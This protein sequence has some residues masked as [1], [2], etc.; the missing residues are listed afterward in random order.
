MF[1]RNSMVTAHKNTDISNADYRVTL[2]GNPNVGKSTIFNALTGLKQ[3][4]GN[5]TGKTVE[6]FSGE[7]KINDKSFEITDLP[8]TYSMISFS[9]EESVAKEFLANTKSDCVVIVIDSNIIERNLSFAL[10]VLSLQRN[11]VLCLNLCDEAEKNGICIDTDELSLN[12]GIPVVCTCATKKKGLNELKHIIYDVCCGNIKCFK[13]E[14][15]FRDIDV[16]NNENYKKTSEQLSKLSE[17]ICIRCVNYNC[18][19]PINERAKKL[20]KILT[21]KATGIPIMLLLFG[22]LFWITAVGANYPSEWLSMLFDSVKSELYILFD[23]LSVPIFIKGLLIDGVYTTLTWVIAV[24]LPPMAIFFP[25]FSLIEDSGYLPRIAFNLDK[26]FSKC[27]AHGKQSLTMAMGIGCNACGVTGCRI[28]ESPQERLVAILT[29]NFMPCNGRFPTLI[30]IIMMFFAGSTFGF[31][32]SLKV[33]GILLI[34][35]VLCVLVT[36][37]ISKLLSVTVAKGE[38]SGFA[39][40]LPP[41]RKPQIF[42]TIVRSLLDRTLFVLGRAIVVSAPA[43]AIIW[44][45][46]NI[47][48]NDISILSYCT[49]FLDPFGK[50]LGLDGVIIMAFVL[51]FPANETV[52]PIIIMSYMASGTLTDFTSYEQLYE[53]FS[54]NG[55]TAVTAVCMMIMCIMHFPCSTTCLTIKKET[56]NLKWT[57][58]SMVFPTLI[59]IIFCMITANIMRIF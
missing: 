18:N 2:T 43:G 1:A 55:W 32:S 51:G 54:A 6:C 9:E 49:Q 17:E 19:A 20:D 33:A 14:R 12:L 37:A 48:I 26:F 31:A 53:I 36:L 10:Q 44:L 56:G 59:G 23:L 38:P 30:A 52:V 47:Y 4:T 29:N 39:L 21:S 8:G 35:I 46:A 50:F 15:L 3:H 22:L 57:L 11:A 42:K 7:S 40:E 27:G 25:L 58:F 28:I 5:W 24:M 13:I 41:Y 16:L 34:I 45:T